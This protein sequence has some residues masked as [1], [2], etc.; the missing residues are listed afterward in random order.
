MT[1]G[2]FGVRIVAGMDFVWGWKKPHSRNE[3]QREKA[4][5]EI[6][7]ICSEIEESQIAVWET[8]EFQQ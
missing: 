1:Q 4:D 7:D 6:A 3:R 5:E 2:E 8:D